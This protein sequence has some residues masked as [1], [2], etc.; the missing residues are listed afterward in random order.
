MSAEDGDDLLILSAHVQDA[1]LPSHSLRFYQEDG[2]FSGLC[3]RFCWEHEDKY[4]FEDAPLSHR[5]HSGLSFH[6]VKSVHYR[7][8]TPG[9]PH[10]THLNLLT[11]QHKQDENDIKIHLLFSG[12][13]EIQ[14]CVEK[15]LCHVSDLHHPWPA[16]QKP[17]H[18]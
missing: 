16:T 15:L 11:L 14:L 18:G 13:S 2:I 7:G 8:F 9:H 3:H 1:L 12:E 10:Y 6:H 5:V 17:M 4:F